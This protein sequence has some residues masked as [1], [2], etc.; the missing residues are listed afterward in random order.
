LERGK[1]TAET[2]L[3]LEVLADLGYDVALQK[4]QLSSVV[5]AHTPHGVLYRL[6]S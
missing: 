2:G 5:P 3:V 4:R 1:P 6:A